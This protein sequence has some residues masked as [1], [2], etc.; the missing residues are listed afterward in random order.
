M[1]VKIN[2]K[3]FS[4]SKVIEEQPTEELI[5][6]PVIEKKTRG[7]KKKVT[8][9]EEPVI[10]EPI[11]EEPI[12]EEQIEEF[13]PDTFEELDDN[14]LSELNSS[15][16]QR[17]QELEQNRE[18]NLKQQKELDK[19][20][21]EAE[22]ERIK[23]MKELEKE[24]AKINRSNK[25]KINND[26]ELYSDEGTCIQGK[27]KLLLLHKIKQY[28][29][30]FPDELKS[31]K[32]KP[33]CSVSDLKQYIDEIDVIV[34]TSDV[35]QFLTD[36]ILQC[37]KLIEIPTSRTKN[38]N[39]TGLSDM[40]KSNKQFHQLCKKLYLKYGCFDNVPPEYQLVL[41]VATTAYVCKNKNSGRNELELYL[42]EPIVLPK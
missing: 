38:F 24:Q 41:L 15:N 36:S 9:I 37:I 32:I 19:Q 33:N 2:V 14:F 42:N 18:A 13:I 34:S 5:N 11:I 4:R 22:K 12:I 29:T 21:K 1:P 6:E 35:D 20:Q 3:R 26:N 23:Y 39:I 25:A 10:E 40:L 17:E 8:I 30:L 7:R 28:K 16:Y 31:F 27:E